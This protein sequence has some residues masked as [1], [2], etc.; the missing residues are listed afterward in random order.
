MIDGGVDRGLARRAFADWI[1]P[2]VL[3]RTLKGDT[4]RF[5]TLVLER[6]RAFMR[7][8]LLGGR[9]LEEGLVD[10]N[11]LQNALSRQWAADGALNASLIN[12]LAAELWL[13]RLE[14][15][16]AHVRSEDH[17]VAS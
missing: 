10:A 16:R 2:E 8:M 3:A 11:A 5:H 6:N 17:L 15:K 9:L 7:E 13:R 14:Q 12:C 4:T 1:A